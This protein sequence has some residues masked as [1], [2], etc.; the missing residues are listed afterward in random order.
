MEKSLTIKNIDSQILNE[1]KA[2]A[3]FHG[4]TIR[5]A[6]VEYMKEKGQEVKIEKRESP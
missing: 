2:W 5:D 3:A 4:M 1:F 6:L